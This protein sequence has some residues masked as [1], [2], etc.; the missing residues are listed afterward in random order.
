MEY[1]FRG[2]RI[3]NGEWVIGDLVAVNFIASNNNGEF[4]SGDGVDY[5]DGSVWCEGNF[6][7]VIPETVGMFIGI[8]NKNGKDVYK[9]D[10]IKREDGIIAKVEWDND[11]ASFILKE[12]DGKHWINIKSPLDRNIEI[13]GNI[14]D[15]S[16]LLN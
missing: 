9:G 15:N 7:E 12:S 13:I 3:D 14:Y 6:Y 5:K 16:N 10:V 11:T 8:K 2:K 1:K 4:Y